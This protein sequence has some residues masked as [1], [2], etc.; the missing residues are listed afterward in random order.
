MIT[1]SYK[2]QIYD[3]I[4]FPEL[5]AFSYNLHKYYEAIHDIL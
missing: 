5:E 2:F 1:V 4:L 3:E